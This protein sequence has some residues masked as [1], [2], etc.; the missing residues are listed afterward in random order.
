MHIY[1]IKIPRWAEEIQDLIKY[2][3]KKREINKGKRHGGNED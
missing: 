3:R 2:G 1:E